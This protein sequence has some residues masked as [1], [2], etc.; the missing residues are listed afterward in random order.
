MNN[1]QQGWQ[2]PVCKRVYAPWVQ[3]CDKC[4]RDENG[5]YTYKNGSFTVC[6]SPGTVDISSTTAT[7]YDEWRDSYRKCEKCGG[8]MQ[9]DVS[10]LCTS[11]P[12]QRKYKCKKCG[13]IEYHVT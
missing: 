4:G 2:C 5:A 6:T 13:N 10:C 12:P 9:V 1:V 3:T 11:L 7:V 8:D